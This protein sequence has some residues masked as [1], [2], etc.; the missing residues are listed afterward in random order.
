MQADTTMKYKGYK[1][2]IM[3][4]ERL[5]GDQVFG[6]PSGRSLP[7]YHSDIFLNYP[8]NWMKGP[9]VF[10]VPVNTNKGLWFNFT[11]NDASNTAV[12]PTVKGCNPL[13]GLQT[14]GFHMERYD[15]KCPKHDCEFLA[16]RFC[17]ECDYKWPFG[18]Y[19]AAPNVLWLDGW[20]N[21]KDGSI[22]QLFFTEEEMRDIATRMIGNENTVPAF[23]FAFY[24]PKVPRPSQSNAYRGYIGVSL[25][26]SGGI[27]KKC[28]DGTGDTAYWKHL[29]KIYNSTSTSISK[30]TQVT[31]TNSMP[32]IG[33]VENRVPSGDSQ[34]R[35]CS[36][37]P[38][39][40]S[41]E[42]IDVF[43]DEVKGL[44]DS[45]LRKS[46]KEV[47]IGAGAK[48][49]QK[50]VQDL[51]P[52]DSWCDKPEAVM[53]IYFVFHE[54]FEELKAGGLRDLSGKLEGMLAGMPVG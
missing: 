39:D 47:S 24:K 6:L 20:I 53:T 10:V 50:L 44:I 18:N 43:R 15:T 5:K 9:S 16:D 2:Q 54:K 30:G 51:F 41:A 3:E 42:V 49:E 37:T 31:Y 52:L 29:P 4:A 19:I 48:I 28:S 27:W 34:I 45:D 21:T 46:V 22:R 26:S 25:S 14:S 7:V 11:D 35:C 33:E 1:A 12:I 32:L 38:A 40:M 13:T 8:E 36:A 17:P 23:G